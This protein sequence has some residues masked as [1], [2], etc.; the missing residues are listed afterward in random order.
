MQVACRWE[1][2]FCRVQNRMTDNISSH[3]EDQC[4]NYNV[5]GRYQVNR[6]QGS[7]TSLAVLDKDIRISVPGRGGPFALGAVLQSLAPLQGAHI[8]GF[9]TIRGTQAG[10]LTRWFASN[11]MRCMRKVLG[12]Y[13]RKCKWA[14]RGS[15]GHASRI[16]LK[17]LGPASS[18]ARTALCMPSPSASGYGTR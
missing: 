11:V 4:R 13:D 6:A 8:I 15:A 1:G 10:G 9:C 5:A 17:L 16:F 7:L 18:G 14:R 3:F 12:V 2:R